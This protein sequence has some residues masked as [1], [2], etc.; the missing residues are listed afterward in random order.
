MAMRVKNGVAKTISLFNLQDRRAQ[1]IRA[2][3]AG[4]GEKAVP[5]IGTS[6]FLIH[7]LIDAES[8]IAPM[9]KN[10]IMEAHDLGWAAM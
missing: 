6:R 9:L 3:F 5:Q 4:S 10:A 2:P 7:A 1:R 8:V